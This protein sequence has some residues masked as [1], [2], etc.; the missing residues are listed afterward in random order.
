M[1]SSGANLVKFTPASGGT[2]DFVYSTTVQGFVAP[3]TGLTNGATY[4]FRS[5]SSD[6]S[7]WE[8]AVGTWTSASSTLARTTIIASSNSGSKVNF[9]SP[10]T[11]GVTLAIADHCLSVNNLSDVAS[12]IAAFNALS[13]HGADIASASTVN[14][15]TATGNLVDVTGTTTITAITLSEGKSRIVRFTGALTLTHG[16]SLVLPGSANITTAAGDY[17]IFVGYAAGVVRCV[18]YSKASGYAVVSVKANDQQVFTGSGTWTKPSGFG[19]KAYV[20]IQAWGGGGGGAR[21][22]TAAN[23]AGGGGGGYKE[24]WIL[25]SSLG[26]TETVTIAAGGTGRIT[27]NGDGTAGGNTTFGSWVTAYGGGAGTGTTTG[28]GGG[29]CGTSAGPAGGAY[30]SVARDFAVFGPWMGAG[31]KYSDTATYPTTGLGDAVYG[32]AGGGAGATNTTG[33]TSQFGGNGGTGGASPTAGSQPGG[34][35]GAGAS[36]NGKDGGAGKV[37]VTVFDGA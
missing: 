35:G 37:I 36:T 2:G 27:S 9:T 13:I 21:H 6:L 7:Q 8:L 4:T 3:G 18:V 34:G 11:V 23:A 24:R 29:G 16:S 19:S 32:G 31:G 15:D 22:S 17:A 26:A 25:L 30:T 1:A 14:L 33:G 20:L 12:P 10:P 28:G 5:E